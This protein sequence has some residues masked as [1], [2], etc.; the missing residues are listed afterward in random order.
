[1]IVACELEE[2]KYALASDGL[3]SSEL[4]GQGRHCSG[5]PGMFCIALSDAAQVV[6]AWGR[7]R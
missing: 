1:M 7:L 2:G 4:S 6:S 5:M 3:N